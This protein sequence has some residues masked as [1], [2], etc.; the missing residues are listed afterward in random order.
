[1][2]IIKTAECHA[3]LTD[4]DE[5]V[6]PGDLT[7]MADIAVA[8]PETVAA[9]MLA[10]TEDVAAML[11]VAKGITVKSGE[12]PVQNTAIRRGIAAAL[13]IHGV[14]MALESAHNREEQ[15]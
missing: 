3:V 8:S 6:L 1:M 2:K 5:V 10:L 7:E 14:V 15:A 13:A 12:T 9:L 4:D 11:P